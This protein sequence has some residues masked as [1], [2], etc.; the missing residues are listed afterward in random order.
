MTVYCACLENTA[1]LAGK[2]FSHCKLVGS[3]KEANNPETAEKLWKVSEQ[4]MKGLKISSAQIAT[5]N[6]TV[7]A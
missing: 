1:Q 4:W 6:E 2:F 7:N 5:E 3:T